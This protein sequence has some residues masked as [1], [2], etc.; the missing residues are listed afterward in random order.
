MHNAFHQIAL[1]SLAPPNGTHREEQE[2]V[3][4]RKVKKPKVQSGLELL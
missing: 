2:L 4:K 1:H 3:K